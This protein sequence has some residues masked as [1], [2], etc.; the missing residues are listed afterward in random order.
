MKKRYITCS[1]RHAFCETENLSEER[2]LSHDSA[3]RYFISFCWQKKFLMI[4]TKPKMIGTY[5]QEK[6]LLYGSKYFRLSLMKGLMLFYMEVV[7]AGGSETLQNHIMVFILT[8]A[9][10]RNSSEVQ[11]LWSLRHK[12]SWK[13]LCFEQKLVKDYMYFKKNVLAL[14][15]YRRM[16]SGYFLWAIFTCKRLD[17]A[18]CFW[19]ILRFANSGLYWTQVAYSCLISL[20]NW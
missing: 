4:R 20:T 8:E 5:S 9:N 16:C 6:F 18:K 7:P 2:I 3:S 11:N 12:L 15:S 13:L 17:S 1:W 19:K 10:T 14:I